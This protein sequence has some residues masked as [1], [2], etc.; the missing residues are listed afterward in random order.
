MTARNIIAL[1]QLEVFA[2]W[3]RANDLLHDEHGNLPRDENGPKRLTVRMTASSVVVMDQGDWRTDREVLTWTLDPLTALLWA[4]CVEHGATVD[5]GPCPACSHPDAM[6]S[7]GTGKPCP[8]CSVLVEVEPG[9]HV[10]RSTGRERKPL[11]LLVCEAAPK[12]GGFDE[13][14][15]DHGW[16]G[17]EPRKEWYPPEPGDPAACEALVVAAD[18]L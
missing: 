15:E 3:A 1:A 2:R 9:K 6:V 11:A 12:P 8:T 4:A 5:V 14:V 10:R 18:R 17:Q 13:Y 7:V 16:L